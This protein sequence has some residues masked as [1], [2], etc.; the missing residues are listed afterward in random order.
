MFITVIALTILLSFNY[1]FADNSNDEINKQDNY[2]TLSVINLGCTVILATTSIISAC[3]AAKAV[4][5]ENGPKLYIECM[6]KEIKHDESDSF[7]IDN[8]EEIKFINDGYK[9]LMSDIDIDYED[10]GEGFVYSGSENI[11][12]LKIINNGKAP[13]SHINIDYDILLYKNLI[14]YGKDKSY[15]DDYKRVIHNLRKLLGV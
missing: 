8:G 2:Q 7:I 5:Y 6:L 3:I 11:L 9:T 12:I 1:C 14:K 15:I 13:A 10:K 4:R